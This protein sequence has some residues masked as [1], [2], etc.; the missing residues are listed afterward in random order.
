MHILKY[1]T[2]TVF[3]LLIVFAADGYECVGDIEHIYIYKVCV[4]VCDSLCN[5]EVI[6]WISGPDT[7]WLNGCRGNYFLSLSLLTEA[8]FHRYIILKV[9]HTRENSHTTVFRKI[10]I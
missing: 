7:L 3:L 2:S 4:H 10:T 6:A 8:I 5:S 9:K 1:G